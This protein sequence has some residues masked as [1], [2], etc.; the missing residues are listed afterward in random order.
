MSLLVDVK[1]CLINLRIDGWEPLFAE[2]K[3][4]CD[5]NKIPVPNMDEAI[6]RWGRSRRDGI[7][8][9]QDHY[10][11]VDP[12]FA[13]IDAITTEMDHRFNEVSS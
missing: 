7:I 3:T 4:F 13:A 2:V 1:A 9:T 11:R 12:F 8:V 5:A 6:P 10:Y